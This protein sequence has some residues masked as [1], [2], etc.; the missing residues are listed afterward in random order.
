MRGERRGEDRYMYRAIDIESRGAR[1]RARQQAA[2]HDRMN[3]AAAVHRMQ[4][5]T[6]CSAAALQPPL[7]FDLA[8]LLQHPAVRTYVA[9]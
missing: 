2:E 1:A 5:Q 6:L 9:S 4:S 8:P 3:S 7:P